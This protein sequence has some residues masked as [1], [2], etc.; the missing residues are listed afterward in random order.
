MNIL[1]AA[2]LRAQGYIPENV[3][4]CRD[5]K[6]GLITQAQMWQILTANLVKSLPPVSVSERLSTRPQKKDAVTLND[7][8]H[9]FVICPLW[10]DGE[11]VEVRV[12]FYDTGEV[13]EF[14]YSLYFEGNYTSKGGR[15]RWLITT[16]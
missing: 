7:T 12:R 8:R 5:C 6:A 3:Q 16:E 11:L 10:Y 9:G 13:I 4:A 15:T 1:E 2:L 14:D